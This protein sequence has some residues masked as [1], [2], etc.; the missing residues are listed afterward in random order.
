MSPIIHNYRV[1]NSAHPIPLPYFTIS[2]L[3]RNSFPAT[4]RAGISSN[5]SDNKRCGSPATTAYLDDWVVNEF[6]CGPALVRFVSVD[7]YPSQSDVAVSEGTL[8]LKI[9]EVIVDEYM[10]EV[11]MCASLDG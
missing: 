3:G 11:G 4:V 5:Y 6:L 8:I 7:L 10:S 1:Y 9:A 2:C